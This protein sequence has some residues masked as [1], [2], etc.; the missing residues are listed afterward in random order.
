MPANGRGRRFREMR[1][2]AVLIALA[3]MA[4]ACAAPAGAFAREE[5]S[6]ACRSGA[7]LAALA[8]GD[9]RAPVRVL[10]L[11]GWM[12][13]AASF[14]A[15]APA[16]AHG[17]RVVALDLPGHGRSPHA[18]CSAEY[19][20]VE[21]AFSAYDALDALG[22]LAPVPDAAGDGDGSGLVDGATPAPRAF[23]LLGHS[24]G[25]G[26]ACLLASALPEQV[27]RLALVEGFGPLARPPE[28]FAAQLRDSLRK[29][30]AAATGE[31]GPRERTYST[32]DE[33][34][35]ARV[36]GAKRLPGKQ[37]MSM[38]A[39]R[40]LAERGTVHVD[41]PGGGGARALRFS[42]DRR[43][44]HPNAQ[45]FHEE[46]IL[47]VLAAVSCPTMLVQARHGWPRP[48]PGFGER[49]RAMQP[50]LLTVVDLPEGSHY[51]HL[52]EET[53]AAV[54]RAIGPFLLEEDE[55]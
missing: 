20:A 53:A 40:V 14:E 10:A 54:Q 47:N 35:A 38:G 13:N 6:L 12:D 11:H 28:A 27:R 52:D 17:C 8:W 49:V 16:L 5:L 29:R 3:I 37:F 41:A 18:A 7:R 26:I 19:S 31:H 45:A 50:G 30:H 44:A 39:A 32:L 25:G 23:S 9:A 34:A 24:L 55:G 48:E 42:H 33:A 2:A 43:L 15:L 21:H 1:G 46:Q 51:A 4:V 36:N 22:W